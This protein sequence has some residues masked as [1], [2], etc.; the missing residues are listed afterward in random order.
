[1]KPSAAV[2]TTAA[3]GR[4]GVLMSPLGV[5]LKAPGSSYT[6]PASPPASGDPNHGACGRLGLVKGMVFVLRSRSGN[7]RGCVYADP[8]GW[9]TL[10]NPAHQGNQGC[11]V[12]RLEQLCGRS[13]GRCLPLLLPEVRG[14][15]PA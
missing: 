14:W 9:A 10:R 3:S 11:E 5:Q 4:G 15:L 2:R 8:A 12:W 13:I 7:E 6:T 1:T